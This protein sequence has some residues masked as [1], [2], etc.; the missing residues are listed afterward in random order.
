MAGRVKWGPSGFSRLIWLKKVNSLVGR[1]R[2]YDFH[3][4]LTTKGDANLKG[5]LVKSNYF[6]F[7]IKQVHFS[8]SKFDP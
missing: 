4:Q 5:C 6:R 8:Q 1:K 2:E 3:K 7:P